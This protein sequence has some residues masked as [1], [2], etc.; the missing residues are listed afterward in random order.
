MESLK[1]PG[2]MLAASW[3]SHSGG[4]Q[5]TL[6]LTKG[7]GIFTRKYGLTQGSQVL[8]SYKPGLVQESPDKTRFWRILLN[9]VIDLACLKGD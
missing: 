9:Q 6:T 3:L 8:A 1:L 5:T 7:H 2:K 4:S